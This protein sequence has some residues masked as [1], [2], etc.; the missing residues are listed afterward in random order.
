MA[1]PVTRRG[2]RRCWEGFPAGL[3]G[4]VRSRSAEVF[5]A[6]NIFAL[7]MSSP[8]NSWPVSEFRLLDLRILNTS[9]LRAVI[10]CG[11]FVLRR[12]QDEFVQLFLG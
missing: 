4:T 3:P 6:D 1:Y 2:H 12:G 11:L 9:G 8:A 7:N 5:D 10:G